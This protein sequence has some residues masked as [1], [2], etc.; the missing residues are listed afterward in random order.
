M[1]DAQEPAWSF[2]RFV[3]KYNSVI[4]LISVAAVA[5]I[6]VSFIRPRTPDELL[7]WLGLGVGALSLAASV[8]RLAGHRPVRWPEEPV[9]AESAARTEQE[10]HS[11]LPENEH[12]PSL[13]TQTEQSTET[14]ATTSRL[15][16]FTTEFETDQQY[17]RDVESATRAAY[18]YLGKVLALDAAVFALCVT[19]VHL[20]FVLAPLQ[21]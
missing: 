9:A 11:V 21:Q 6:V 14:C 2:G 5:I 7:V 19:G 20:F 8:A 17:K 13:H 1:A 3:Y 15:L 4:G 10:E 12:Q 16:E 18:D